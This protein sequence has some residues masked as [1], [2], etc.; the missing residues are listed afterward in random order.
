MK[1]EQKYKEKIKIYIDRYA[2]G[3]QSATA[4]GHIHIENGL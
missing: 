1:N 3:N 4:N 2:T